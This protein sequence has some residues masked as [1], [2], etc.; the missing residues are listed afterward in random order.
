MEIIHSE[1]KG[2][3]IYNK[4]KEVL[5]E[6]N[7]QKIDNVLIVDHTEVSETLKGQGIAGKLFDELIKFSR[8]KNYKIDPICTYIAK[9]M[10]KSEYNDLKK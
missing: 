1:G 9:K 10:K 2:F 4:N 3:F 6:L 7:Y 5:A 8:K